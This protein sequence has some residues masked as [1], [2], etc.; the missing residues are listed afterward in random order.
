MSGSATARRTLAAAAACLLLLPA[1]AAQ[2]PDR[3][4]GRPLRLGPPP[5]AEPAA[6]PAGVSP[7]APAR[8]GIEIVPARALVPVWD[9]LLDRMGGGL[10]IGMWEGTDA[11]TVEDL[12]PR[13]PVPAAS[14]ATRALS[15][16]LL[17]SDAH[18]PAGAADPRLALARAEA[19]AGL[20]DPASAAALV[21]RVA[22]L[23]PLPEGRALK[24]ESLLLL[25]DADGACA[26]I[27]EAAAQAPAAL[28]AAAACA[29]IARDR[30]AAADR[31]AAMRDAGIEPSPAF[32]RLVQRLTGRGGAR[33]DLSAPSRLELALAAA[34]GVA[35]PPEAAA[36][37][38]V[39]L[40]RAV[41]E[42]LH[43]DPA[44]RAAATD[45]AAVLGAVT[46]ET[47]AAAYDLFAFPPAALRDPAAAAA[48][49][50][51]PRARALWY[52]AHAAAAGDPAARRAA[53]AGFL[54]ALPGDRPPGALADLV[55]LRM[56][57][58]PPDAAGAPVAAA[59]AR[60]LYADGERARSAAWHR[61][62]LEAPADDAG[63]LAALR[64]SPLAYAVGAPDAPGGAAAL[65]AW[66]AAELGAGDPIAARVRVD[67]VL[68]VL[69]ALGAPVPE[70]GG[71]P[72]AAGGEAAALADAA[73]RG[74]SGET[75]L[76]ALVLLGAAGPGGAPGP[77]VA[78]A[79]AALRAAGLS[80][81]ARA[82]A[83]E[84]IL[85]RLG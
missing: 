39:D 53:L 77:D 2:A 43:S 10:G 16:R 31:L 80:D 83:A 1:A 52:Q 63:R 73:A 45:R 18:A 49:L 8:G 15:L 33:P 30:T 59:L 23:A 65:G 36:A 13:L 12:L 55:A 44:V 79:V 54:A 40:L 19:A 22:G 9:G 32:E 26:G 81:D 84:A 5:A 48:R 50:E 74:R 34:A 42:N 61:V 35:L 27:A 75:A 17:L 29:A 60:V 78:A 25:G 7:G 51:G 37:D 41:A 47:L 62:A 56:A 20:G 85:A 38:R 69:A 67:D 58:L 6:D 76:R 72:P 21:D 57:D 11:R 28:P 68:G 24:A 66:I 70:R 71:T 14:P 3:A 46:A 82:V 4:P 64:L